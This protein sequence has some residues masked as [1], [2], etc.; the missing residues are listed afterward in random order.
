MTKPKT[1]ISAETVRDVFLYDAETGVFRWRNDRKCGRGRIK[2]KA[3]DIT[4]NVAGNGYVRLWIN[5]ST[6][7]AHR[8]AWLYVYGKHPEHDID[9]VNGNRS[10]NK[11][12]N[13]R[14][15]TRRENM[16][17]ARAH[18]DGTSKYKGVGWSKQ[19]RKWRARISYAGSEVH[20]GFFDDERQA[21]EAYDRAATK[22]FGNFA[23]C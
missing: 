8:I 11:I 18:A 5:G 19:K 9:H 7:A 3:G 1:D 10:D 16:G 20:L 14:E 12:C 2:A 13:L 22:Y 17:N 4:G 6:Y 23:G 21:K 15:A